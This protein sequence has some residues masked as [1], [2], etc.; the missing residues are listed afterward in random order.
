MADD[1][2]KIIRTDYLS[3]MKQRYQKS[4]KPEK[5][6]ILDEFIADSEMHRKS[7]IR[8]LSPKEEKEKKKEKK[9]GRKKKYDIPELVKY[10]KIVS[11]LT[12]NIC[13]K[14][15]KPTLLIFLPFYEQEYGKLSE[16]T[17]ELITQIS[18][19]TIDR[20][21][22]KWFPQR[23]KKGLCT[24]KPGYLLRKKI[25]I[26]TEQWNEKCPGF[27]EV[28]TVAHCGGSTLGL[29]VFSLNFVDIATSWMISRAVWGKGQTGI[30]N[31]IKDIEQTLPF[32]I[33]GFDSDNGTEFINDILIRY[34]KI[35][36]NPVYQTRS[37]EYRKNDN[38]H[39][40]SKNWSVT[41]QYFGYERFDKIEIVDLLNSI[42]TNE[43]YFFI[44]FFI[45]STKLISKTR[46]GSK[47]IKK[48][49]GN[50]TPFQRVIESDHV[51]QKTKNI[52]KAIYKN[53]N[54]FALQEVIQQQIKLINKLATPYV[55]TRKNM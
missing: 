21:F 29:Y 4:D 3:I 45:P 48:H 44:N 5:S 34:L 24:T 2:N 46:V 43:F 50:K 14:R 38:A 26:K 19:R 6:K 47:I 27:V 1:M 41:R 39:I 8:L 17:K 22:A 55:S 40:E 54:P 11:S 15:L 12:N 33:R 23:L 35:R 25:P 16:H 18:P 49:D 10:I 53:L 42:Y 9:K 32:P 51:S 28:D 20:I 37:R 31:A 13:S 30:L 7:A 52:L 36:K